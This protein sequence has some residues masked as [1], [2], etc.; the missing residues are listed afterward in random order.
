MTPTADGTL[1]LNFKSMKNLSSAATDTVALTLGAVNTHL[2]VMKTISR[3]INNT[4]P[5]FD[6]LLL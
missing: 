5:T 3:A 6:G 1:T 2:D 4:R